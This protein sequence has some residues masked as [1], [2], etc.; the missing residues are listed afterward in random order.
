MKR[1]I[2]GIEVAAGVGTGEDAGTSSGSGALSPWQ[3]KQISYSKV[4]GETSAPLRSTPG[5]P[6]SAPET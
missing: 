6:A 1:R 5:T 2:A 3:R 4:A